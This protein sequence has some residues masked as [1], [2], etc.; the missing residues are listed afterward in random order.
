MARL[1]LFGRDFGGISEEFNF[2]LITSDA[3]G[4]IKRLFFGEIDSGLTGRAELTGGL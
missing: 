3:F 2:S 4:G 1:P